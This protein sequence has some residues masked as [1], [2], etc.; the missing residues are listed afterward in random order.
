MQLYNLDF[1]KRTEERNKNIEPKKAK[2]RA[3]LPT[4]E[5]AMI[6]DRLDHVMSQGAEPL[7]VARERIIN[8]TDLMSINYLQLGLTVAKSVCR[9]HVRNVDGSNLGFGTGFLVSPSLLLTNNHIF[10]S[11]ANALSLTQI[12]FLKQMPYLIT[13]L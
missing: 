12:L 3:I 5:K 10:L 9:I 2:A 8:K 7:D 13:H 1:I 11:A 4:S 6:G